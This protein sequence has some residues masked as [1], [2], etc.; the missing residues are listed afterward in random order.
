MI[1]GTG[2]V[3]FRVIID[4]GSPMLMLEVRFHTFLAKGSTKSTEYYLQWIKVQNMSII[5]VFGQFRVSRYD[6]RQIAGEI[7]GYSH[8][9]SG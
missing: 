3:Y 2:S 7:Q 4:N 8:I 9:W 5:T 6:E 1:L